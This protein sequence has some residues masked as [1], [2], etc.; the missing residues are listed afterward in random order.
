MTWPWMNGERQP[1]PPDDLPD[2]FS[3]G[4]P[5]NEDDD[6]EECHSLKAR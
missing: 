6:E 5:A 3:E 2:D 1:Q 4:G